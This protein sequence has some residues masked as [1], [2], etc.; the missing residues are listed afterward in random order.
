MAKVDLY[1]ALK[2]DFQQPEEISDSS[3]VESFF[4]AEETEK[5]E[6][7]SE[8][9]KGFDEWLN[10]INQSSDSEKKEIILSKI[11]ESI[12]EDDRNCLDR[13]LEIFESGN[14]DDILSLETKL[15]IEF[16]NINPLAIFQYLMLLMGAGLITIEQ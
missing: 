15:K 12:S 3:I 2:K 14:Q 8:D 10:K 4:S 1:S 13:I 9:E 5:S 16:P 6:K 7:A 11:K